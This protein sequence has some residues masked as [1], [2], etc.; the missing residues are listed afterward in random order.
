MYLRK[1]QQERESAGKSG[2]K[3]TFCSESQLEIKQMS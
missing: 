1:Q 3:L 2:R